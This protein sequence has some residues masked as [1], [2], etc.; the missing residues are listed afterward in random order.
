[1]PQCRARENDG[2]KLDHQTLEAMRLWRQLGAVDGVQLRDLAHDALG[3][4]YCEWD[5]EA[6]AGLPART[7][8]V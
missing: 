1:L 8:E 6:R 3:Y 7:L 5:A 4:Q 2:W